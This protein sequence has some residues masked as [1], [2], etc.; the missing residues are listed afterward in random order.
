MGWKQPRSPIQTDNSTA[1]GFV[2]D[3]IVHRRIKM[4]WMRLHWLRC[5]AAQGQFRFYW[6]KSGFNLADY[7][8]KHH[9]PAYHIAHRSTHAG[10][11]SPNS[12]AARVCCYA[13]QSDPRPND[14]QTPDTAK[15]PATHLARSKSP[16]VIIN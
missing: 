2:N 13:P 16:T 8:T 7:H 6:D 12:I 11:I 4:L 1:S 9:P 10:E 14:G 5:R 15:D 3:T